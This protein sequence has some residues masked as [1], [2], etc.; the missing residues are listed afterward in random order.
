[1]SSPVG[2]A[3]RCGARR[4]RIEFMNSVRA[5]QDMAYYVIS[6]LVL[7]VVLFLNRND[8]CLLYTSPSPRD[9]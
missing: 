8:T 9:S 5:G 7:L 6:S 3:A 1:M 2:F 4:G